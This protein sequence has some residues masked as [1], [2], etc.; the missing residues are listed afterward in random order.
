MNLK[1]LVLAVGVTLS[2]LALNASAALPASVG[3]TITAVQSDMQS[4]FDLIFP[5]V[6]VGVGLTIAIKLF[7]RF[8]SKV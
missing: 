1:H 5:V 6:A 7:K 3:S 2:T 4:M 8:T